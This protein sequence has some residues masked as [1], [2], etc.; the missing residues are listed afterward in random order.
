MVNSYAVVTTNAVARRRRPYQCA[1]IYMIP[2]HDV[3]SGSS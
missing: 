2:E 1:T 3:P